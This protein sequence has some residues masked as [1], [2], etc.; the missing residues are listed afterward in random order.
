MIKLT[1]D[2]WVDATKECYVVGKLSKRTKK[3]GN[4]KV[5]EDYLIG[6][7]YFVTMDQVLKFAISRTMRDKVA[8]NDVGTLWEFAS[9]LKKVTDDMTKKL[10]VVKA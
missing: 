2:L 4:E 10:E 6:Q 5:E 1:D 7:R 3:V 8:N 9:K